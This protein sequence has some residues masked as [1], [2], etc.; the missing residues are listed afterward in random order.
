MT[1]IRPGI[2]WV[3]ASEWS[4]KHFHGHELSIKHG[5]TYN[6]Y[7]IVDEKV[8]L[9]D[10]VKNTHKEE[11]VQNVERII[12]LDKIDYAI[13]NHSEPDHS[14][15]LPLIRARNPNVV[16]V[17]NKN[18]QNSLKRHYPLAWNF[19]LMKTNDSL[20]LGKR[21]LKFFEA[22]M[23]HWPD[24]MFSYC[25]E[26]K[27]LFPNDA[28]GQHYASTNR[29]ADEVDQCEL[30]QEAR[31][32]FANILTPYSQHIMRKG[33]E[34]IGM[35]WPIEMICPSHGVMW[36]KD[37]MTI[38]NKYMEWSSGAAEDAVVIVYDTIWGGTEKMARAI[39]RGVELEGLPFRLY[40]AGTADFN[41]VMTEVHK[42]KGVL[43][44]SPTLNNG[45][46]P[47]LMPYLE[48]LRNLRFQKKLGASFGTYG[49]SGECTKR[50]EEFLTQGGIKIVQ[51]GLRA[52]FNPLDDDLAHCVAF[53]QGFAKQV[54]AG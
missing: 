31:K 5:T 9:I 44:G 22:P 19:Q 16:V 23:L 3:G 37:P 4:L 1:Q 11:L 12:P 20:S 39:A 43:V 2:Y 13:V 51:M 38:V 30:W 54:K 52:N 21:S 35:G 15:A 7:L 47:T 6:S 10:F 28:F 49:W 53:G 36:R 26:E 46:M 8:A 41:D 48:S 24:S 29:Y 34:F 32:Y 25:P 40:S 14:G 42:A 18:G 33:A 50:I 27:I 17:C 45:L